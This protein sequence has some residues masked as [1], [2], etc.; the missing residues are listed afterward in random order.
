MEKVGPELVLKG[1]IFEEIMLGSND[2][3]TPATP[4]L[5]FFQGFPP[6]TGLTSDD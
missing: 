4:V 6:R 2:L 5:R 3:I 1:R